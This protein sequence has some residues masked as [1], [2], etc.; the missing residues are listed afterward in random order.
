MKM[1][2]AMRGKRA[3]GVEYIPGSATGKPL[4]TVVGLSRPDKHPAEAWVLMRVRIEAMSPHPVYRVGANRRGNLQPIQG[5]GLLRFSQG[6]RCA[7]TLGCMMQS[8]WDW[9]AAKADSGRKKSVYCSPSPRPSPS[10]EGEWTSVIVLPGRLV[11][12]AGFGSVR[13]KKARTIAICRNLS[14]YFG[15]G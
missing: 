13:S 6:R 3:G 1:I 11:G 7:P 12:R 9:L 8:L 15:G 2:V 10:G 5:W 14:E 4:E